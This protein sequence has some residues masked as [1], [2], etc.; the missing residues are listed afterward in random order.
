MMFQ[1]EELETWKNSSRGTVVLKKFGE[2]GT[3]VDEV[4][5]GGRKIQLTPRERR[6]NQEIAAN[7]E[8]DVFHNGML[9]PVRLIE[10]E[11]DVAEIASNPN[12]ITDSEM[13][14]LFKTNQKTFTAKV[15]AIQSLVV[16]ERLA[17]IAKAQDARQSQIQVIE[18]RIDEV[19]PSK[20]VER[21]RV[22]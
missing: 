7:E 22:G 2:R 13:A 3:L 17:E 9:T 19:N 6:Y 21:T 15:K 10:T 8:L 5:P 16:L 11:E 12:V 14:E 18:E 4:V 1:P 20:V